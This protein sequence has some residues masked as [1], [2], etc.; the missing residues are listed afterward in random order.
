[1]TRAEASN[2]Y[3]VMTE[4]QLIK[5][6]QQGA[7]NCFSQLVA[8][9][10]LRLYSYLLARCAHYQEADDVLQETF[11]KAYQYLNSYNPKWQFSTWLFTIA[12][13]TIAK[14]QTQNQQHQTINDED[15]ISNQNPYEIDRENIWQLIKKQLKPK[16]CDVLWFFYVEQYSIK[17]I[18][19]IMK[20]SESWV[21]T[22]LHR[23]KIKLSNNSA[24]ELMLEAH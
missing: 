3:V 17:E 10:Q 11:I 21:K 18:S 19:Q 14:Y 20:Q 7:T 22:N 9:Y 23:S 4:Q 8:S 2:N 13:R 15:W 16:S 1:M 5:K 24:L 6:A 12:R